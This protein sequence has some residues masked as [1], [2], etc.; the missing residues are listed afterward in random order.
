MKF[1]N[2]FL[3][4]ETTMSSKLGNQNGSRRDSRSYKNKTQT[5]NPVKVKHQN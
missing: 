4:P 5:H 2:R 1:V 3:E